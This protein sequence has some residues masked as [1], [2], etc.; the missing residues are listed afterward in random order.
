MLFLAFLVLAQ[1]ARITPEKAG[2]ALKNLPLFE[3][4]IQ[5]YG[6]SYSSDV[7][8]WHRYEIFVENLKL[9]AERN[10]LEG[11]E[12][13]GVTKFMDLTPIEFKRYLG[14]IPSEYMGEVKL[15]CRK[16]K[17]NAVQYCG[18]ANATDC[19]YSKVGAVTAVK[20]QGQC[21]SCWAF[22][23]TE[24][25]ETATFIAGKPLP[26]LS[27]QE[28][29]D[30]DKVDGGCNGGDTPTAYQFIIKEGGLESEASYPYTAKDGTCKFDKT[31]VV[32]TISD[33]KWAI[34]PCNTAATHNCDN[35]DEAGLRT[36]VQNSGPVSIC[37]DAEPWQTYQSGVFS[38]STCKHG[39]YD[40]DHCV[41]L[42]G[43]G[44]ENGKQYWL[45]KNSWGT[46]WGEKGYIKIA[47]GSNLCGIADEATIAIAP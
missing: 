10:A 23:A 21:G 2:A 20:D 22:S 28:I 11:A 6:K 39:Y 42:T 18:T 5:T 37:V 46:S 34:T 30:C 9:A 45:V 17:N 41:H 29:V 31:K 38:S 26:I 40:L 35:Q 7:E 1:A 24:A 4:F 47:Y 19:D 25:T 12:V 15:A 27:P 36:F 16:M 32:A 44:V 3:E 14:F 13:H 8:Y 43:Y 33:Y